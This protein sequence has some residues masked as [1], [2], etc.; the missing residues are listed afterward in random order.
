MM[1]IIFFNFILFFIQRNFTFENLIVEWIN[2]IESVLLTQKNIQ[3]LF[4]K[5][6]VYAIHLQL[7]Y[8]TKKKK[9]IT[10]FVIL[11]FF[12]L[13]LFLWMLLLSCNP[14]YGTR[15]LIAVISFLGS[16]LLQKSVK[17]FLKT[18]NKMRMKH[19]HCLESF[20]LRQ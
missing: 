15:R 14:T 2:K 16:K 20:S 6:N 18:V 12:P 10:R 7:K 11:C 5:K 4:E 8:G 9:K 13:Y 3:N 17:R 19:Q 1:M